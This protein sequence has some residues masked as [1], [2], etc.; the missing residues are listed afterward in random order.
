[1]KHYPR[2]ADWYN[3]IECFN[4]ARTSIPNNAQGCVTQ[5]NLN[6]PVL[7]AC[8]N[9]AEAKALLTASIARMNAFG[10]KWSPTIYISGKQ[11]CLWNSSPCNADSIDDFRVAICAAYTGSSPPAIC[12]S[13]LKKI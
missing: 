10:A 5:G 12:N 1:M 9:G 13:L 4:E 11:Y 3:F 8:V 2:I 7:Q 6:Y